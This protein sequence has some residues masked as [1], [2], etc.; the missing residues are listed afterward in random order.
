ML[1]ILSFGL[2]LPR[3]STLRFVEHRLQKAFYESNGGNLSSGV[4]SIT[5]RRGKLS[6]RQFESSEDRRYDHDEVSC[7]SVKTIQLDRALDIALGNIFSAVSG[8]GI[9][10]CR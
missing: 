10:F 9:G 8:I 1:D 2:E 5:S 3:R 7:C 6:S 4:L